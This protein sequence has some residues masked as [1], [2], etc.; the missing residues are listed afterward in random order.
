MSNIEIL[1]SRE[2]RYNPIVFTDIK[3]CQKLGMIVK[4]Y[5]NQKIFKVSNNNKFFA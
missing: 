5:K 1:Y 2:S 3:M 4:S